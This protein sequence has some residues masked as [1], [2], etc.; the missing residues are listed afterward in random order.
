MELIMTCLCYEC[1]LFNLFQKNECWLFNAENMLFPKDSRIP[2]TRAV[3]AKQ[4]SMH[5]TTD[6][7]KTAA[8]SKSEACLAVSWCVPTSEGIRHQLKGHAPHFYWS[9]NSSVLSFSR[10][11]DLG[12]FRL[13]ILQSSYSKGQIMWQSSTHFYIISTKVRCL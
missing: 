13:S 6:F 1:W 10:S 7:W 2:D 3:C 5:F 12:F 8:L 4:K 9:R 11:L